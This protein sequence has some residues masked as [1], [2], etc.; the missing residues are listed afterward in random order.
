MQVAGLRAN[1]TVAVGNVQYRGRNDFEAHPATVAAAQMSSH[2][3]LSVAKPAAIL[4]Q[5]RLRG[6]RSAWRLPPRSDEDPDLLGY[7]QAH[8]TQGH[9]PAG[10]G[11]DVSEPW[12]VDN[13]AQGSVTQVCRVQG[14]Q[15]GAGWR[16]A[17]VANEQE[18][19]ACD[20]G[21]QAHTQDD[22]ALPFTGTGQVQQKR[23]LH[24]QSAD[25]TKARDTPNPAPAYEA[26]NGLRLQHAHPQPNH[27]D[28]QE[29]WQPDQ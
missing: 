5:V 21:A 22:Q 7:D 14:N 20:H 27:R 1:R 26:Q 25:N 24:Q 2:R 6:T 10:I 11:T 17:A 29:E 4:V 19:A 13:Q 16:Q 12:T 28:G 15:A 23:Q 18:C 9:G 8:Y 3:S